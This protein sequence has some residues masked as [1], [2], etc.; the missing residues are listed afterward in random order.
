MTHRAGNT[1]MPVDRLLVH[2]R[3][4]ERSLPATAGVDFGNLVTPDGNDEAPF[5][6]W[7]RMKEAFSHKLFQ[8]VVDSLDLGVHGDRALRVLDPFAGS[9]TSVVSALQSG[10]AWEAGGIERN[11]FL[12]LLAR[13]KVAA[14]QSAVQDFDDRFESVLRILAH[15]PK[16]PVR[17]PPLSTFRNTKYFTTG[18]MDT[19]LLALHAI[20]ESPRMDSSL[21]R[22]I[23]RVCVAS[24][25]EA[26]SMLRRDGRALR[27]TPGKRPLEPVKELRRRAHLIAEDLRGASAAGEGHIWEGDGR[28]PHASGGFES[29]SVDLALFSPP[30]LNNIDYTEVYK[31]EQWLL[32]LT[33]STCEWRSQRRATV[34]SHPSTL[35]EPTSFAETVGAAKV[36]ADIIGPLLSSIPDDRY[37]HERRR[38][39]VGY[40]DDM[41]KSLYCLR[42][43]LRPKAYAVYVVGNSMH[44]GGDQRFVVAAD[45]VM[46]RLAIE[47]GYQVESVQF[48]RTPSRRSVGSP[49]FLRESVVVLR[50]KANRP[51][52]SSGLS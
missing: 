34:R 35:F 7:F 50:K 20:D 26:C 39:V 11:P 28:E 46:A 23:A 4:I 40:F 41:Y 44:G 21:V 51:V 2:Y 16:R 1:E 36:L 18:V 32:G 49:P 9:A 12:S 29:E 27:F 15:G 47:I 19:F 17:L 10:E 13:T 37:K 30:Y 6:R 52:G 25:L 48:A 3:E 8:R 31:M 5:H 22:D 45:I 43:V 42:R 38:S 24:S 33:S 14:L